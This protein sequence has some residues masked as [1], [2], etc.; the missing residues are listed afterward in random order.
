MAEKD[1]FQTA[2]GVYDI[3]PSE[4]K[5]WD[6]VSEICKK[7]FEKAGFGKITM[8]MFEDSSLF[9]G[10]IGEGT[11]IVDKEMYV[12]E[13]K[14]G[15]SLTLRPEFTA[16]VVRAYIEHGMQKQTSPVKLYYEGP[17]FRYEKP[18]AGR[19]RQSYQIGCELIGEADPA[20]D[21]EIIALGQTLF[22][23]MGISDISLQINS[24]GCPRCR[25][26]FKKDLISFIEKREDV[27]CADCLQRAHRNPLR[28][29]DCKNERCQ[30]ILEHAPQL[31][32]Y[33][34]DECKQHFQFVLEYL[35]E[36]GIVYN[37]NTKL[38][39]GLDYYTK[40][41]FEFWGEKQGSQ[42]SL[43]GGGRYDELVKMF[44]GKQTPAIGFAIGVE[45]TILE[46]KEQE[47]KIPYDN[48]INIFIA[49]LG[50]LA[51]KET[52]K[53]INECRKAD[54]GIITYFG[55]EGLKNQ[56]KIADIC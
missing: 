38:V 20:I 27:F 50:D 44:G 29:L 17:I 37:L 8:P 23:K 45:R 6:Y 15:K 24:I 55:K 18:Q 46:M 34:C 26:K 48:K 49:Y 33:L 9:I 30:K 22:E 32:D 12:F 13:D 4:Q 40:T 28:V 35:D 16:S 3:L 47:I 42:S 2:R 31:I 56:L 43:G 54:I 21:A 10:S 51:K 52:L 36:L 39:R 14:G 25:E 11:D 5:Y 1:S 7:V 53:I 41:V 19:F